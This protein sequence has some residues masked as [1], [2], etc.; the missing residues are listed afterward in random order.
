MPGKARGKDEYA[1][2]RKRL[3]DERQELLAASRGLVADSRA[4]AEAPG[5]P[6]S[7]DADV[8]TDVL[9][10]EIAQSLKWRVDQNLAEVERALESLAAGTYGRCEDCGGKIDR[11]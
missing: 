2:A 10:E 11:S 1:S 5:A 4:L 9:A 7:D 6:G 3:D 8:A